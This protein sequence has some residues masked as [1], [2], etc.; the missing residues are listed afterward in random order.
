MGI[1]SWIVLGLV[2]GILAKWLMPGKDPG[3]LVMTVILGTGTSP[4]AVAATPTVD[5]IKITAGQIEGINPGLDAAI[6]ANASVIIRDGGRPF[7]TPYGR[8]LRAVQQGGTSTS[9]GR[10]VRSRDARPGARPRGSPVPRSAR[11]R[12]ARRRR[13]HR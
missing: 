9:I 12:S 11:P 2:V 6:T 5:T 8:Q 7:V 3:G 4:A 13:T 1:L 10:G